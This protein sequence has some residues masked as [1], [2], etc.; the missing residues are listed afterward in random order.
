MEC[1]VKT[2]ALQRVESRDCAKSFY[3]ENVTMAKKKAAKKAAPKKKAAKKKK[4]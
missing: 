1:T 2:S 4:K 3:L